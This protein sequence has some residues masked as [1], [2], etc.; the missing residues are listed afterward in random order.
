MNIGYS[1]SDIGY[2]I[3]IGT[4]KNLHI[5]NVDRGTAYI[6][7]SSCQ[8]AFCDRGSD[9]ISCGITKNSAE[10][11]IYFQLNRKRVTYSY[12]HDDGK[13][14]YE[15]S[16][17]RLTSNRQKTKNTK[18]ISY[19]LLTIIIHRLNINVYAEPP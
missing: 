19:G 9:Y 18:R 15:Y 14:Y 11:Y 12:M 4:M 17:G 16:H 2:S 13:Y 3:S 5:Y 8:Q 1:I 10:K 6:D 7:M